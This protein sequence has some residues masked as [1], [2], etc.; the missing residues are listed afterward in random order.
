MTKT[1]LVIDDD[2]MLRQALSLGLKKSGFNVLCSESVE[3]ATEVLS[4]ISVDA[5]VLDRMMNGMDG[6][7]FLK[8]I[9]A[10]GNQTPVIMLTAMSGPQ[11]TIDGL[12]VGA[13][14]YM[15][16]PF[17][18]AELILRLNNI[19]KNKPNT[20]KSYKL[21]DGL[22]FVD[23]EFFITN[24][25]KSEKK[26]LALSNEEKK[27]LQNLTS[28]VGTTASGT[29]MVAKRLRNKINGVLS[30]I[31]IITVRGMGYKLITTK[32]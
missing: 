16:K 24:G 21:P 8:N 4:R 20:E 25:D 7:T 5:M 23:G 9:R 3:N 28:P 13:D 15:S 26:L 11:N 27:L 14:D 2:E 17:Q 18:L 12:T 30:D 22:H 10:S 6:L 1:V 29:P 31:D 32:R 19:T